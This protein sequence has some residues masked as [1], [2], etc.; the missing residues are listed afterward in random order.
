MIRQIAFITLLLGANLLFDAGSAAATE[1]NLIR[2]FIPAAP[3]ALSERIRQYQNTRSAMLAGYAADGQGMYVITRFGATPQLHHVQS[4]Q[5]VR[6]QLTFFEEPVGAAVPSPSDP[7][8]VALLKDQGGDE[9]FQVYL[10]DRR[11]GKSRMISNG[12][13]RKAWPKWSNAGDQIAWVTTLEGA[14]RGIVV[15]HGEGLA[16]RRV[17]FAAEGSWFP[18]AWS[19]NDEQ[20]ALYRFMSLDQSELHLLDPLS[21]KVNQINAAAG[22]IGYGRVSFAGNS[23][24][25][26]IAMDEG[27]ESLGLF[28][29]EI[30]TGRKTLLTPDV[31]YDVELVAASADGSSF[32]F[33]VNQE[34]QSDLRVIDTQ[35]MNP[36]EIP[37]L[38]P[39]V[40]S[41]LEFESGGSSLA[42]T[43]NSSSSPGDVLELKLD[44]TNAHWQW[45]TQSEAGGIPSSTFVAT[46]R[47][48]YPT[49]DKVDG[50]TRTIPAFIYRPASPGPHPAVVSIH[51]GPSFQARMDFSSRHQ[52]LAA[53]LGIA[54]IVPNVRGSTGFG[55]TYQMLDDGRKREDSVKDIGALLDWIS[56]QP[57]LDQNRVA[58][59]GTSYGGYMVLAS[60]VHYSDRLAGGIDIV[61]ISN[62][63]TFLENTA[64][65]RRA[66][67]RPEYGDERDPEMRS[68]L[69]Q[70]SPLTNADKIRS[71][72]LVIQGLNDPRVPASEAEQI[73]DAVRANGQQAW[74]LAARDE[75]HGFQKKANV[76]AMMEAIVMFLDAALFAKT[77]NSSAA[78]R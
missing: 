54:V 59:M 65:Y 76:D 45:W 21:G 22:P 4:P 15:A 61:G 32:A 42:V 30:S 5:G 8:L 50:K 9:R 75:G 17:A 23:E 33:T 46:E 56:T 52:L 72:L 67:R 60:L 3:P 70:I 78:T 38:P 24:H 53:E 48:R 27:R 31:A 64:E 39:G 18:L 2:E 49:F 47:F 51:G 6:R 16:Q 19:P 68:F 71:P 73:V 58:V 25:M 7:N 34:G 35:S 11:T 62:F 29:Y 28:S 37:A 36:I 74:Y 10:Y 26:Y 69:Q 77:S 57:D 63:V 20:I 12:E 14:K 66:L 44:E 55:K 40:I 1:N 43:L 41:S 13:G